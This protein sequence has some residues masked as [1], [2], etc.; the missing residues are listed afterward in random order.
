L[1][2]YHN[3]IPR[4]KPELDLNLHRCE[5]LKSHK[6]HGRLLTSSVIL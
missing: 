4:H 2:S 3:I 5:N 6:G 1:V